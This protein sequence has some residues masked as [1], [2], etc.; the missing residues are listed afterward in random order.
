MTSVMF[1][2]HCCQLNIEN[3]HYI[4]NFIE[5]WKFLK[6]K[7]LS[8]F[9]SLTLSLNMSENSLFH[10]ARLFVVIQ[11]TYH[12]SKW[13]S[14]LYFVQFKMFMLALLQSGFTVQMVVRKKWN[15]KIWRIN[16]ITGDFLFLNL[17]WLY[18]QIQHFYYFLQIFVNR[19]QICIICMMTLF[20]LM[21]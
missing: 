17:D 3:I 7:V 10:S 1:T 2:W 19:D 14:M 12:P 18:T 16:D 8:C 6:V 21:L 4:N 11:Q 15:D 9:S 5:K 13:C 20:L